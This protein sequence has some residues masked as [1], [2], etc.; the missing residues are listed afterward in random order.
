MFRFKKLRRANRKIIKYTFFLAV[1][2]LFNYYSSIFFSDYGS[3]SNS[4]IL[5]F[6]L[7]NINLIVFTILIFVVF[8][9]LVR[10]FADRRNNLF[11]SKIKRRVLVFMTIIT[12]IP[13]FTM[14][15]FSINIINSTINKWFESRVEESLYGSLTLMSQYRDNLGRDLADRGIELSLTITN[16]RLTYTYER[17]ALQRVISDLTNTTIVD[18]IEVLSAFGGVI[19]ESGDSFF[20]YSDLITNQ[21]LANNIDIYAQSISYGYRVKGDREIFWTIVP[22]YSQYDDGVLLAKVMLYRIAGTID[23][24][25]LGQIEQSY[26]N[27]KDISRFSSTLKVSQ[28]LIILALALG[29]ALLFLGAALVFATSLLKPIQEL[30]DAA[31][32]VAKGNMKVR[33]AEGGYDEISRLMWSFNYMLDELA[34]KSEALSEQKDALEKM[35]S[36]LSN[37]NLYIE[38]ILD[39][40]HIALTL[41]DHNLE[42]L[43]TNR[44]ARILMQEYRGLQG[45]IHKEVHDLINTT[46]PQIG[47][48]R[49]MEW[50]GSS[51]KIA[52]L[53]IKLVKI[54]ALDDDTNS[55]S[56]AYRSE[57]VLVIIDD[58]TDF[59]QTARMRVW[60][61]MAR[62]ITHE[63]KNPLTP[64]KLNT[65]RMARKALAQNMDRND[66]G[67]IVLKTSEIIISEVDNM[68]KMV[69]EFN[70]YT[71]ISDFSPEITKL[72][73]LMESTLNLYDNA[74][75]D[76]KF[77]VDCTDNLELMADNQLL[78]RLFINLINNSV[79]AMG[80]TPEGKI[81][82]TAMMAENNTVNISV[83][84]N[85]K[86]ID[87]KHL[88]KIFTPYYSNKPQGTGLGLAIVH[89]IVEQHRGNISVETQNGQGTEFKITLPIK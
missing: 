6:F 4:S 69:E 8:S 85:G 1:L 44:D 59:I 14:A 9:N 40:A 51:G 50:V 2:V 30:A 81:E 55:N 29:L 49:Q 60:Q 89:K 71:S 48:S 11:G 66:L 27:Y 87:G 68:L 21:S 83:K 72:K 15:F 35:Y 78:K 67:E 75:P 80:N 46:S 36:Q 65:E 77:V 58:V 74:Y 39:N 5:S 26:T 56:G 16:N 20:S 82:M 28:I 37:S 70:I 31:I 12:V 3:L 19:V 84:D 24:Q 73:P 33:V 62:K 47:T 41:Y 17:D 54:I 63:I 32:N 25:T 13:I 61:D 42:E 57:S 10:H 34:S 79:H 64:I 88:D 18:G 52:I 38:A 86:G 76:I 45:T 43:Q 7:V 53:E 22:V 23:A